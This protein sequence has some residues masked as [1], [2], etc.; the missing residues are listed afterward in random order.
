MNSLG[1]VPKTIP[2][3]DRVIPFSVKGVRS[4]VE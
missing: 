4:G 3:F 1:T 2:N